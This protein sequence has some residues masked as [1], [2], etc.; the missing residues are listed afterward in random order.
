M[1]DNVDNV[2]DNVGDNAE[3]NVEDNI[4]DNVEDNIEDN[5]EDQMSRI[6]LASSP[7]DLSVASLIKVAAQFMVA[8]FP[9]RWLLTA[10]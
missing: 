10:S 9:L 2:E 1:E 5:V 6:N 3:D 4:E 8:A 7:A